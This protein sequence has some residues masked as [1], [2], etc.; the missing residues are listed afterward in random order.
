M[1]SF[2][3]KQRPPSVLGLALGGNQLDAVVVR[4]LNGSLRVQQTVTASLALSP[5]SG[6]PELVGREIRNHLDQAGIRERRCAL[7]LP[8][9]WLLM[10]Q[11]KLPDLPEADLGSFIDIE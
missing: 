8:P 4:R 11:V 9:G 2:L 3:K 1:I 5:L 6:D 10:L 7:S